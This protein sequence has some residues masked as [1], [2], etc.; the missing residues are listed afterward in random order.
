MYLTREKGLRK[1]GVTE[2]DVETAEAL[3]AQ[4]PPVPHTK[5]EMLLGY[6]DLQLKRV[7]ALRML[8]VSEEELEVEIRH[9]LSSLGVG[10]GSRNKFSRNSIASLAEREDVNYRPHHSLMGRCNSVAN[11]IY[12]LRRDEKSSSMRNAAWS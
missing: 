12:S 4:T 2:D 6:S 7:K 10:C 9:D 3:L 11:S 8:G 1:L 5:A